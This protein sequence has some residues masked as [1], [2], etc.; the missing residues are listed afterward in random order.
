M[1]KW[2]YYFVVNVDG[3]TSLTPR[4][5]FLEYSLNL[6]IQTNYSSL[7]EQ[8][9]AVGEFDYW[10]KSNRYNFKKW[11]CFQSFTILAVDNNGTTV[12]VST[13]HL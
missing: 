1:S 9:D 12:A 3:K 10:L 11:F 4:K 6:S 13:L 8:F 7:K 5:E 2:T